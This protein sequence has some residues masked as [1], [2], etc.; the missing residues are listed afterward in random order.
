MTLSNS[1]AEKRA[2]AAVSVS[3]SPSCGTSTDMGTSSLPARY[4][5]VPIDGTE[6]PFSMRLIMLRVTL[7]PASSL[8]VIRRAI[9]AFF[10]L[11]PNSLLSMIF[12]SSFTFRGYYS[13]LNLALSG[14]TANFLK[15]Y[16]EQIVLR[17]AFD[18]GRDFP[19]AGRRRFA[20][21]TVAFLKNPKENT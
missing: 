17:A 14:Y 16:S 12:C 4:S 18:D 15:R 19:S 13:K 20:A 1:F 2:F 3:P 10:S 6:T 11:F 5:S 21:Q 8:C 7:S 9:R